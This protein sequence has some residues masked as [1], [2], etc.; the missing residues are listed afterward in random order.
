MAVSELR[1]TLAVVAFYPEH[2]PRKASA[3]YRRTHDRLVVELDTPCWICGIRHSD[4]LKIADE[5]ER[6][7]WQIETHHAELEWAAERAFEDDGEMFAKLL[8]DIHLKVHGD[9]DD[10]LR[11]WLDSEGNMLCLCAVHHRGGQTGIHSTPYPIW[12]LQRYQ[13]R[14]GFE[15]VPQP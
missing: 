2:D 13:H 6:R 3:T 5:K 15:F 1:Q 11:E 7:H 12:K 4:V 14:G 9:P 8:A 10:A